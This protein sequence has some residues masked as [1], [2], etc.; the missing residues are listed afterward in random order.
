[1]LTYNCSPQVVALALLSCHKD[2][3]LAGQRTEEG[4]ALFSLRAIASSENTE[5]WVGVQKTA[6]QARMI[7]E[8]MKFGSGER[9]FEAHGPSAT[10]LEYINLP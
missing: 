2:N 5:T 10:Y 6:R 8:I 9:H 4:E 7:L 1:M 3:P